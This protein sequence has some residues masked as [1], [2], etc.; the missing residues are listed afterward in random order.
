MEEEK[1]CPNCKKPLEKK[2][3]S[4]NVGHTPMVYATTTVHICKDCK[5]KMIEEEDLLDLGES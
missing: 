5:Y 1:K 3:E 4:I 2:S